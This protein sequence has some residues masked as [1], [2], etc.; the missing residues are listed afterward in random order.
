MGTPLRFP[1]PL[2]DDNAERQYPPDQVAKLRAIKRLMDIG[3]RPG[4]LMRRTLAELNA[5]A[6]SARRAAP[7]RRSAGARARR[8]SPP[9]QGHNAPA[10]QHALA[11]LLMRQGL[12][13]F[14]LETLVPLNRAVGEAWMRGELQVFEEHLYTEQIQ[15]ALRTRRSTPFRGRP[16]RPGFC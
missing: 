12:Q 5:L 6:D 2:R 11:N 10:L 15:V 4:K 8:F 1:D 9:R 13:R 14:V 7:R 16:A 3:M